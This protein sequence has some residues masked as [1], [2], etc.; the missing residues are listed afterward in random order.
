M[1]FIFTICK[2]VFFGIFGLIFHSLELCS[3]WVRYK[4][5][6]VYINLT[7][8]TDPV[9]IHHENIFLECIFCHRYY[10]S[11]PF[12]N[13][14]DEWVRYFALMPGLQTEREKSSSCVAFE[15]FGPDHSWY[16]FIVLLANMLTKSMRKGIVDLSSPT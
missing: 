11:Y 2:C 3:I 5:Q 4:Y 12:F 8:L 10:F 7:F 16:W 15:S 6:I 1:L 13:P 9:F 14:G